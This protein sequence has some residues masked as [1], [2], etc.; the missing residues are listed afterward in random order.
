MYTQ[1]TP[2][3][4]FAFQ[5]VE[6]ISSVLAEEMSRFIEDATRTNIC[7]PFPSEWKE[8]VVVLSYF[9]CLAIAILGEDEG[10][11]WLKK[12]VFSDHGNGYSDLD[13]PWDNQ[14][15][16]DEII[17]RDLSLVRLFVKAQP[18]AI[19]GMNR[20]FLGKY[21][22]I[23]A[24]VIRDCVTDGVVR[25]LSDPDKGT[26][27]DERLNFFIRNPKFLP[28]C[29]I[30]TLKSK[31]VIFDDNVSVDE[32]DR[33]AWEE[34]KGMH[35][36]ILFSDAIVAK[37]GKSILIRLL[38][39]N[40][41][42]LIKKLR[43]LVKIS[44][45]NVFKHVCY[46]MDQKILHHWRLNDE[47]QKAVRAGNRPFMRDL[48]EQV[49]E[50]TML[51]DLI[52]S[53]D[54]NRRIDAEDDTYERR[55]K[56]VEGLK[57][58][59]RRNVESLREM[60]SEIVEFV[61]KKVGNPK[62]KIQDC[63]YELCL[64]DIM[65]AILLLSASQVEKL[66]DELERSIA[67]D[68]LNAVEEIRKHHKLSISKDR[69]RMVIQVIDE[70]GTNCEVTD[71]D[72]YGKRDFRR[73][74]SNKVLAK[75]M[76]NVGQVKKTVHDLFTKGLSLKDI[77]DNVQRSID[78]VESTLSED[79]NAHL[80]YDTIDKKQ[81]GKAKNFIGWQWSKL[82]KAGLCDI[83]KQYDVDTRRDFF[84]LFGVHGGIKDPTNKGKNRRNIRNKMKPEYVLLI[85]ETVGMPVPPHVQEW[86][87]WRI[88]S[89]DSR[90]FKGKKP[91]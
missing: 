49:G 34:S 9:G 42:D 24:T 3:E 63:G 10:D 17:D 60:G 81:I 11:K 26:V 32:L 7:Q 38:S 84:S 2:R 44:D 40:S 72:I 59:T 25:A 31:N 83:M 61:R 65:E 6:G 8:D 27:Q 52:P 78:F 50:D 21:K 39:K 5:P 4:H 43:E 14:P 48:F 41:D 89:R 47:E 1:I 13:K 85:W 91:N 18:K 79:K 19:D 69:S 76:Q 88:R 54:I 45:N 46:H 35:G 80:F 55:S 70:T 29:A 33:L 37:R 87:E 30:D 68:G 77:V 36:K 28:E 74:V 71:R 64:G 22:N 12:S 86:A 73:L 51:V 62:I 16:E 90:G 23:E 56:Q 53:T 57:S 20:L 58:Y 15:E 75:A 82:I 66:F 67:E